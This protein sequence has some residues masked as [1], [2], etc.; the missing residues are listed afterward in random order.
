MTAKDL[1]E[2]LKT[3]AARAK[4]LRDAGVIGRVTIGDIKF[5]LVGAEPPAPASQHD[6]P[7]NPID[8][9][10]TYGGHLPQP[11]WASRPSEDLDEE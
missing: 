6:E 5:E 1:D 7:T 11:R 2:Q 8:D 4:E 3:I 10:E 9:P